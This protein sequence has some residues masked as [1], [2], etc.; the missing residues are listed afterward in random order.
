MSASAPPDLF[1][2]PAWRRYAARYL[3]GVAVWGVLLV[4]VALAAR[5]HHLPGKPWVYG[6]TAA[7]ALGI[8][9]VVW[10]MLRYLEEEADEYQRVL[11]V[12]AFVAASGLF[13]VI[14]TA[15]G[16]M[17]SFAGMSQDWLLQVFPLFLFCHGLATVWVRWRAR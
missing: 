3:V 17:Q 14:A 5:Y 2:Q 7:P 16:Q 15:W 12:R 8:G 1:R 4:P 6:L 10:S 13:L 11:N 9:I